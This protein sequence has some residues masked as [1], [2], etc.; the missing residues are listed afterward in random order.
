M[1]HVRMNASSDRK[2]SGHPNHLSNIVPRNPISAEKLFARNIKAIKS[3]TGVMKV[4]V[5]DRND[6]ANV[7]IARGTD[8]EEILGSGAAVRFGKSSN[9]SVT[10]IFFIHDVEKSY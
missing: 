9:K 1:V 10:W 5:L 7:E 6:P 4:G 8:G 2:A 3:Q